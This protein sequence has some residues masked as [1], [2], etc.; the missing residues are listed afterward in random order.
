PQDNPAPAWCA[1]GVIALIASQ[2]AQA[3]AAW[4]AGITSRGVPIVTIAAE[5]PAGRFTLEMAGGVVRGLSL[6]GVA[7]PRQR[8]QQSGRSLRLLDERGGTALAIEINSPGAI[9]WSPRAS[10]SP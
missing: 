7:V 5:D 6:E 8:L 2:A 9:R 3:S 10:P 1:M 4:A